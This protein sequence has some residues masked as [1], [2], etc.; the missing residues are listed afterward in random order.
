MLYADAVRYML[1]ICWMKYVGCNDNEKVIFPFS[2]FTVFELTVY[3]RQQLLNMLCS[4][5][6]R[7]NRNMALSQLKQAYCL[8]AAAALA[9]SVMFF[10]A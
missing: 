10:V 9:I 1:L 2:S 8:I 7:K 3:I 4:V 6:A 5:F